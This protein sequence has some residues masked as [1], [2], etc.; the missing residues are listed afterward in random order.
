MQP[1]T[2]VIYTESPGSLTFEMQDVP[3]IAEAAHARGAVVLMDNTWATP[4]YFKALQH[5][6]D[7]AIYAA[8][9]YLVGHADVLLGLIVAREE[10]WL[11]VKTM[12]HGLGHNASPDDSWLT[13][14]GLRTLGVRL[15]RHQANAMQLARWLG[16]RPEVARVLYPALPDDPGHALWRRD[17]AGATGLF[18]VVLKPC[19]K[20][21]V[22]AMV[23]GLK[24]FGLGFSWGGYESLVLHAHPET[25]RTVRPW[26]EPGPMVRFHIGLE[27]PAD[28][29]ADLEEGFARLRSAA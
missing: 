14:R 24:L 21:A 8:T 27:E 23:N 9:K 22:E 3:A 1:N 29:V 5:G 10:H 26:T 6:V 20:T 4:L 18:S 17:F 15:A 25:M 2:R 11:R 19:S 13:L 12:A 16:Q 28:L 7:V